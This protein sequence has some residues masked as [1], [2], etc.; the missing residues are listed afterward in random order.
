MR[1][2]LAAVAGLMA[3]GAGA[4]G[5]Q[6]AS[7]N[8]PAGAA[9]SAQRAV[10]DACQQAVDLFNYMR[11]QLGIA[12]AGGN[13]TLGQGGALGGLPHFAIGLRANVLAGSVP[14]IQQPS[15]SGA[16]QRPDYPT[17]D[18]PL[19]L[20]AV[21]AAIGLFKGIPLGVSN[22][23]GIDLLVS[24]SYVPEVTASNVSVS[25]DNPI[26]VGYGV[27]IGLLQESLLMPEVGVSIIRRGLPVTTI[28]GTVSGATATQDTVQVADL[29]LKATSWRLTASKSLV[30]FTLAAGVGQD[31]YSSSTTINAVV[32]A[33]VP[34]PPRSTI[35]A[36]IDE[37]M[38]RTNYFAD[39]ALNLLVLKIVGEI[40]MVSGG[41][42]NTFNTFSTKAN[43]S[44]AYGSV[45][46][47]VGF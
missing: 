43:A 2:R 19:G 16:V 20:P 13:A 35:T 15:T 9:F 21:D 37:P 1:S 29:D 14:T 8:C 11:P 45:G 28:T 17:K 26:Q 25:P 38:T 39:V 3:F 7:P 42:V 4:L 18:T 22:V 36:P 31:K 30:L 10:Q 24:A 46:I 32:H 34:A 27:R 23:G 40:G 44:R 33:P 6:T 47:R 5:A 12:I 41:E